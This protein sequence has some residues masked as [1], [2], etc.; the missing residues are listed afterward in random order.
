MIRR[1]LRRYFD[2]FFF[3]GRNIWDEEFA[4]STTSGARRV[5]R[6]PEKMLLEIG[7]L[8][9]EEPGLPDERPKMPAW[10]KAPTFPSVTPS[11][12]GAR[13]R[14]RRGVSNIP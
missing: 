1:V 4:E 5:M 3:Y 10:N 13:P 12:V 6:T 14:E 8:Y 7:E 9:D 11:G 2:Q